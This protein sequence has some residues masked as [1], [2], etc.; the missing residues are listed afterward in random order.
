MNVKPFGI[1]PSIAILVLSVGL[2]NHVLIVPILLTVA[3]RDAWMAV[4]LAFI[5]ILPWTAIPFFNLLKKL[6]HQRFDKWLKDRVHPVLA[7]MII[8]YFLIVTFLIASETLIVTSSWT[9]TT[10]LPNTPTYVVA[11]VFLALCLYAS[12]MG[13]RTIAFM[14]CLLVPMVVLLGDFVMSINLPHKDYRYLLPMLEYGFSPVARA[15]IHCLTAFS[16]LFML[17]FIQHHLKKSYKR[18][19]LILLVLFLGLLAVGPLTGA[20][21]EFGPDEAEKMRYPAFSQWRLVSIGRYFEHVD[22][23]AIFQWLS[24]ALIRI[25]LSIYLLLEFNPLSRS[26]YR[27]I[28]PVVIGVLLCGMAVYWTNHMIQYRLMIAWGFRYFGVVT[29]SLIIIVY[30]ISFMKKRQVRS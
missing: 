11:S 1:I 19:H 18:W 4:F 25:S 29:M 27:W 30:A 2:V 6:S 20:I 22:F 15:S 9:G 12:C 8:G 17:L 28:A 14:S 13:L 16:E 5:V 24:G 26:K 23:F 3:K 21:A 7:W 10:Y